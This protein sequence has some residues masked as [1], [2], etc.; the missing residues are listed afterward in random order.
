M[1]IDCPGHPITYLQTIN[2]QSKV[3]TSRKD[4]FVILRTRFVV[5]FI[6]EII[7]IVPAFSATRQSKTT[8]LHFARK[9]IYQNGRK[10]TAIAVRIQMIS[11]MK[12]QYS[13]VMKLQKKI[14]LK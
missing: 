8:R 11:M 4:K 7:T 2:K 12:Y 6:H 1:Y 9:I 5:Q 10:K 13:I 14:E 3:S